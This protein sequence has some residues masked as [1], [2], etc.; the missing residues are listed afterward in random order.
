[1]FVL[2]ITAATFSSADSVLTTLTTSFIIDILG[3]KDENS[4]NSLKTKNWVHFGF[5]ILLFLVIALFRAIQNDAIINSVFKVANYTYGPLLGLFAFGIFTQLKPHNKL[6][7]LVCIL[8]PA[9]CYVLDSNAHNW[10]G[11]KFG[12]ELL[13]LNGALTF[14]GLYFSSKLK[15]A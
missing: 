3:I 4:N 7:P 13:F 6:V 2:G 5:S 12:N 1:M 8:A 11:Y 9:M 14:A 10:I 15:S